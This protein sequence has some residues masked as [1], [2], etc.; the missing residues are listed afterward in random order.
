MSNVLK[1]LPQA[2]LKFG[3]DEEGAQV[4]EYA[5]IIA[6]VSIALVAALGS[7]LTAEEGGESVFQSFVTRVTACLTG[8]TCA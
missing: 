6:V 4:I 5:L 7:L 2:V 1:T 8:G 3:R